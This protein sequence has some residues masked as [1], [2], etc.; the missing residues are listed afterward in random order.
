MVLYPKAADTTFNLDYW[1]S[2]HMPLCSTAWPKLVKWESDA[3]AP[4]ADYHAVA[5]LFFDSVADFQE[6]MGSPG[7]GQVMGGM[8]NYFSA[9]PTLLVNT[10]AASSA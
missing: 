7:A 2:T 1:T 5:H 10:V 6:S 8:P 4:E 9:A 3:C